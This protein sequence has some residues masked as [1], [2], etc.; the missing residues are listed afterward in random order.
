MSFRKLMEDRLEIRER[1]GET[2]TL[3]VK[4]RR[5][6]W[7]FGISCRTAGMKSV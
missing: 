3:D 7:L 5:A 4:R 2:D 1:W 6:S